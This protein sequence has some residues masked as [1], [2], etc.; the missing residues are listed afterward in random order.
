MALGASTLPVGCSNYGDLPDAVPRIDGGDADD[1]W[2]RLVEPG[3]VAADLDRIGG[4]LYILSGRMLGRVFV[5]VVAR[6][7]GGGLDDAALV[8]HVTA[9]LAEFGLVP[10]SITP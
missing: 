1:F 4:Q 5:S 8:G 7:A 6:P 3:M 10:T 9:T 2:V